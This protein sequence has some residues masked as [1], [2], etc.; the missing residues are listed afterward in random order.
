MS[1]LAK[2]IRKRAIVFPAILVVAL[3]AEFLLLE[4]TLGVS[5]PSDRSFRAEKANRRRKLVQS[6]DFNSYH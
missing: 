2:V 6:P 4:G 1:P 5:L 3:I